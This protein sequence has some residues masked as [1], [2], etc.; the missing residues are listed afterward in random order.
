M[1]PETMLKARELI[2]LKVNSRLEYHKADSNWKWGPFSSWEVQPG[3]WNSNIV[4]SNCYKNGEENVGSHT[5][6]VFIYFYF[7]LE[8]Y[9][10][11]IVV[12]PKQKAL[13]ID[14]H[15]VVGSCRYNLT[16]RMSRKEYVANNPKCQ[17]GN[18]TGLFDSENFLL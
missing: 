1:I 4:I 2:N 11:S 15:P 5:D 7:L 13:N 9:L 14:R 12:F 18:F 17:C 8:M 16:F 6:K 10:H 3:D